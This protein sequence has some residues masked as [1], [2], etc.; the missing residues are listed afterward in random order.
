MGIG[1]STNVIKASEVTTIVNEQTLQSVQKC[2][3]TSVQNQ[4][5]IINGNNN[6]ISDIFVNQNSTFNFSC[7]GNSTNQ[8]ELFNSIDNALTTKAQANSELVFG[9]SFATNLTFD[10]ITTEALNKTLVQS[11]Q[12]CAVGNQQTQDIQINGN[13]NQVVGATFEQFSQIFSQ[14]V[15]DSENLANITNQV[16]ND[17]NAESTAQA[18]SSLVAIIVVVAIVVIVV[19]VIILIALIVTGV[20]KTTLEKGLD[21]Y[22]GGKTAFGKTSTSTPS[23]STPLTKTKTE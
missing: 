3:G 8:V 5:F 10:S 18:G 6:I 13:F 15:F 11:I 23:T 17:I 1:V 19:V 21:A 22:T 9:L 7:F 12:S 20:D 14:C 4:S 16:A 2:G